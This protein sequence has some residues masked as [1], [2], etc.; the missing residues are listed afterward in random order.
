MENKQRRLQIAYLSIND[1]LDKRSWSGTTYYVAK[2]LQRNVGDVDLL[3]P[4][5]VPALLDKML[6]GIAKLTRILLRKEYLTQCSLLLAWHA[7]RTLQK[8]LAQKE[9]DFIFA[10]AASAALA[11]LK[12]KTPVIYMSDTTFKLISN[13][14][15]S[16]YKNIVPWSRWEGNFLEKRALRKSTL[17][18]MSSQWAAQSVVDDYKIPVNRVYVAALGANMDTVPPRE[19]IYE[20]ENNQQLSLLFLGV[21]WVRKGGDIALDAL[22]VLHNTYHIKAKLTVCG[23]QPPEGVSHPYMEVIPFLNK[24]VPEH[25]ARFTELLATTHFLLL[26][27]RADCSLLVGCEA[28]AYGVPAITTETGGVPGIVHDGI[29]GY[30][31]PF[32]AG[33]WMYATLIAELFADKER[34]HELVTSSRQ[35]FEDELNWDKWAENVKE[36]YQAFFD[37]EHPDAAGGP[38]TRDS[39]T[40]ALDQLHD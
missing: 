12:T 34:Y 3:G 16:E 1:P 38:G 26:P 18:L 40:I 39:R 15:Y 17:M 37:V 8:K 7:A 32:A 22:T 24:N 11:F 21:D 28:N 10:P 30:C 5:Q 33:G 4:V 9:Y 36:L 25:E 23:C 14:N 6:R 19:T 31:V 20:K 35:R 2:T 27:T 13:Y 29:N